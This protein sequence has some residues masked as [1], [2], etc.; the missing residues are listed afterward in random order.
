MVLLRGEA[1]AH[2]ARGASTPWGVIGGRNTGGVEGWWK[3]GG[4]WW[5]RHLFAGDNEAPPLSRWRPDCLDPDRL[6]IEQ[7]L[8]C[9]GEMCFADAFHL[10]VIGERGWRVVGAL[11]GADVL[12]LLG[13][14]AKRAV[15]PRTLLSFSMRNQHGEP[16]RLG[17]PLRKTAPRGIRRGFKY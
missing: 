1:A 10:G 5:D 11:D 2:Q 6:L 13:E 4:R 16:S 12:P 7:R 3:L 8:H 15:A 14:Q 9:G 17:T